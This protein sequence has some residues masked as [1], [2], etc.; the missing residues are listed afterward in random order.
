MAVTKETWSG[1]IRAVRVKPEHLISL[2]TGRKLSLLKSISPVST[3]GGEG[4]G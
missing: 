3:S 1:E 2:D 4:P